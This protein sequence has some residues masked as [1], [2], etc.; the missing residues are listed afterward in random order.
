M[1]NAVSA[2]SFGGGVNS[3]ALLLGMG[4]KEEIPTF[5]LFADTGG[6]FP[7]TYD[8]VAMLS[9]YLRTTFG[10]PEITTI[11]RGFARHATLEQECHNLKTLPSIAFGFR[12]CS[13]KWKRQPMDRWLKKNDICKGVWS[14]GRKVGRIIGIDYGEQHRGKI[15]DDA[16]FMYEFPLIAWGWERED[17]ITVI[18]CHDLNVPRKSSCFFCPAMRKPEVLELAQLRPELF[19][20]AV[21]MEHA[22][23]DNLTTIKGLGRH[24]S[25]EGFVKSANQESFPET[26]KQDCLCFDGSGD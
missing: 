10:F 18:Q 8:Y 7:E 21:A 23:K 11:H 2:V 12:G 3:T 6:E 14:T 1:H 15:P 22:A 9:E 17:C 26:V 16:R 13:V 25:W 24:W 20:R 4:E 5:I 19:A